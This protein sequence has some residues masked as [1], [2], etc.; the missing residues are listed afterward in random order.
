MG[1]DTVR[2]RGGGH[3]PGGWSRIAWR[4]ASLLGAA[5][6]GFLVLRVVGSETAARGTDGCPRGE[7][8]ACV[9]TV[10]NELRQQFERLRCDHDSAFALLYLR[11]TEA[12]RDALADG[13]VFAHDHYIGEMDVVFADHYFAAFDAWHDGGGTPPP[14]WEVALRAAEDRQVTGLGNVVLGLNAH[15]RNDLP[16]VVERLGTTVDG[17][18]AE[19][20][21]DRVDEVLRAVYVPAREEAAARLSPTIDDA[22]LSGTSVDEDSLFAFVAQLRQEAWENGERLIA[23]ST[24]TER[25]VIAEE[26]RVDAHQSALDHRAAF[27]YEG[28]GYSA[29]ER[30]AYCDEH[31]DDG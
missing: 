22:D 28:R 18:S 2:R 26:I 3:D 7:P 9:R 20:D 1:A 10:A 14:A 15:I 12:I 25:E 21:Y 27:A 5:L 16:F 30:D 11:V 6:V 31:V 8:S 17:G 29:R 23:A 19:S 13:D 4:T 24:E